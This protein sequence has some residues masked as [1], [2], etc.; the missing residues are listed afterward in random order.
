MKFAH[1]FGVNAIV[2]CQSK[3]YYASAH[4]FDVNDAME[5]VL[6]VSLVRCWWANVNMILGP[7]WFL[8]ISN[9]NN[10]DRSGSTLATKI[11]VYAIYIYIYICVCIYV[12]WQVECDT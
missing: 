3:Y 2:C 7:L 1:L 8:T 11:G 4:V 5:G 10:Y 6:Y 12:P 9:K